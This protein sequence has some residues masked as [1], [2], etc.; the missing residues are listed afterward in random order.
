M[1]WKTIIYLISLSA[2]VYG[3]VEDEYIPE[4]DQ[5][6]VEGFSPIYDNSP[7][8][9]EVQGA[10]SINGIVSNIHIYR[11][12]ILIVNHGVGVHV[13]NNA[14]RTNPTSSHF[15]SIPNVSNIAVHQDTLYAKAATDLTAIVINGEELYTKTY[16]NIF[17]T[18][19]AY[20]SPPF[21]NIGYFEC[22]NESKGRVTGWI[23]TTLYDPQCYK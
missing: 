2:F 17:P 21:E 11:D 15:I 5:H 9:I 23:K 18:D 14:D 7:A 3:C 16:D 12:Q 22:V 20:L 8:R 13:I 6:E 19:Q 4:F 10:R 1:N